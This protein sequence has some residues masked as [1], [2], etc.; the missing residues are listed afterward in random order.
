MCKFPL[1]LASFS[2]S[3][4]F[5][6]TL[7]LLL[8][9]SAEPFASSAESDDFATQGRGILYTI[10]VLDSLTEA[11]TRQSDGSYRI[12]SSLV[13][14]N[15]SRPDILQ[16]ATGLT[17]RFSKGSSLQIEGM[18]IAIGTEDAPITLTSDATGEWDGIIFNA[19]PSEQTGKHNTEQMALSTEAS[20]I[21]NARVENAH[22]GIACK[23]ASPRIESNRITHC[24][25]YAI[26]LTAA[27]P[28][29]R[30]NRISDHR[31]TMAIYVAS[32]APQI[33]DNDL[34]LTGSQTGIIVIDST[35][36]I[37]KNRFHGGSSAITC[38]GGAPRIESNEI[39]DAKTGIS[40]SNADFIVVTN[41][42][43]NT[44][45]GI[46]V[47]RGTTTIQSNR[48]READLVAISI[49]NSPKTRIEGNIINQSQIGVYSKDAH[50]TINQNVLREN[51]YA[52]YIKSG[53]AEVRD[54]SV[55]KNTKA[56][57]AFWE[58]ATGEVADNE[59]TNNRY[60]IYAQDASPTIQRNRISGGTYGIRTQSASP[61]ISDNQITDASEGG[62]GNWEGHPKLQG[63]TILQSR[64]GIYVDGASPLITGN[65]I[66]DSRDAGIS[67]WND[68]HPD[69]GEN[70]ISGGRYE[71]FEEGQE[72]KAPEQKD[73]PQPVIANPQVSPQS[74]GG[75]V[76]DAEARATLRRGQRANPPVRETQSTEKR[77]TSEAL[78]RSDE[79]TG[80]QREPTAPPGNRPRGQPSTTPPR[81]RSSATQDNPQSEPSSI[82]QASTLFDTKDKETLRQGQRTDPGS[83]ATRSAEYELVPMPPNGGQTNT[84]YGHR[85]S[86]RPAPQHREQS[87]ELTYGQSQ[88][89]MKLEEMLADDSIALNEKI[90]KQ[91]EIG[92]LHF[93][94]GNYQQALE[95]YNWIVPHFA[96]GMEK[97]S[98]ADR[99]KTN[100]ELANIH[101]HRGLSYYELK[102][103]DN[104]TDAMRICLILNP[105]PEVEH[106]VRYLLAMS[107]LENH[108]GEMAE[109]AFLEFIEKGEKW[110]KKSDPTLLAMAYF[111]TGRLATDRGA[112]LEAIQQYGN[113]LT[114][115]LGGIQRAEALSEMGYLSFQIGNHEQ[116]QHWYGKLIEDESANSNLLAVAFLA[117]G[118]IHRAAK[119]WERAASFYRFAEQHAEQI[120]FDDAVRGEIAFKLG[121]SLYS[122]NRFADA[123]VA[124]EKAVSLEQEA[125]WF[126]DAL[127]GLARSQSEMGN[128]QAALSAYQR[129]ASI[130]ADQVRT[131]TDADKFERAQ[132]RLALSKFQIA[133]ITARTASSARDYAKLIDLYREARQ[134]GAGVQDETLRT[135]LQ[136]DALIGEAKAAE[137]LGRDETVRE[138][139]D[140]LATASRNDPVGLIQAADLLFDMKKYRSAADIYTQA[141]L[142]TRGEAQL[143]D[144]LLAH[145]WMRLGFAQFQLGQ[146]ETGGDENQNVGAE[147]ERPEIR[148][149]RQSI[150]A[151][152]QAIVHLQSMINKPQSP[153]RDAQAAIGDSFNL[154]SAILKLNNARYHAAVAHKMLGESE[155]A[156]ERFEQVIQGD[157]PEPDRQS[158]GGQ[159]D[160]FHT[161]SL[162]MLAELYED[163]GRY[164]E[165]LNTYQQASL[166]LKEAEDLALTLERLGAIS[167]Q[168]GKYD[169]AIDYYQ[170]LLQYY[171]NSRYAGAAQYFIGLCHAENENRELALAAYEKTLQNY[172]DFELSIDTY[173]NV[174]TLS[175]ALGRKAEALGYVKQLINK[176]AQ[177]NDEHAQAVVYSARNLMSNLLLADPTLHPGGAPLLV[178]QL[179]AITTSPNATPQAQANAYFELGNLHANA[180]DDEA[181][182]HAYENAKRFIIVGRQAEGDNV[183]SGATHRPH[184]LSQDE[185]GVKIGYRE[186]LIYFEHGEFAKVV[187]MGTEMLERI[188]ALG[189]SDDNAINPKSDIA[190]HLQYLL[191]TSQM[192]LN[193]LD[194]AEAFFEQAIALKPDDTEIKAYSHFYL[195]QIRERRKQGTEAI[196]AYQNVLSIATEPK[197]KEIRTEA[198]RQLARIYENGQPMDESFASTSVLDANSQS[199]KLPM[200]PGV[201]LDSALL[202][203]TQVITA[204]VNTELT[205]EALYRSGAIHERRDEPGKA[206]AAF[207]KLASRFS[208]TTQPEIR[209]MVEDAILRLPNLLSRSGNTGTAIKMAQQAL[210]VAQK[211]ADALLL[212]QAQ[213][214]LATLYYQNGDDKQRKEAVKLFKGAYENGLKTPNPDTTTGELINASMFQ[215]G[216]AAY[217]NQE[218]LSA[219]KPLD[220]FI[221]RFPKDE[222]IDTAYEYL[223][224]SYFTVADKTEPRK[225][226]ATRFSKA[227]DAFDQLV[228]RNAD[229]EK[230]SEWL[231]QSA[232]ALTFAGKTPMAIVA[233]Q[234][235]VARYPNH[236]LADD[237][238]YT[239][240]GKQ[241]ES[242][243]YD[244]ALKT[245]KQLVDGYAESEWVDE[246]TYAIAT[247]YEKLGQTETALQT[248]Q[249]VIERFPDKVV[250]VN[251]Q[252]N[253]AHHHFNL[254]EYAQS[255][256]AYKKL[257]KKNF[258][259]MDSKLQ[260]N[261]YH[262]R[263]DTENIM[264][265]KPYKAAVAVL[266]KADTGAETASDE[267]KE[268]ALEA[269]QQ[270][271][272]LIKNYP[273]CA[274]VDYALAS[275]GSA[276]EIREGWDDALKTYKQL[277]SRYKK[278]P[279]PDANIQ[280]MVDYAQGRIKDIEVFLLQKQKFGK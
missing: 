165:A 22:I 109:A 7:A 246:S 280:K 122:Q 125:A 80:V 146:Q 273:Y 73:N 262:W 172:P 258:P 175:D 94:G 86:M 116:A 275:I 228:A 238:L 89:L 53:E 49:W 87:R 26:G 237:S 264:A 58:R 219:I 56:G 269:I 218:W 191:G 270:F 185:L 45:T 14:A 265:E 200:G 57:I 236:E 102:D 96:E 39:D 111:Q 177:S 182:L 126:A 222:K 79:N 135:A 179:E 25:T 42:I 6:C 271:E 145:G 85:E 78:N 203:Y 202:F 104:A 221:R 259:A 199:E 247:C 190:G 167:R 152:D 233:Y 144:K 196:A 98:V 97:Q 17:L 229:S 92:Q 121:E 15:K 127:Y 260:N 55:H 29:V 51:G 241:F 13:I 136:K 140:M 37:A 178:E 268:Y 274:Y 76:F 255:L 278:N 230:S 272:Q 90:A 130:Y 59:I 105:Q 169:A 192:H 170:E 10:E 68:S 251:A 101:Y 71:I 81:E 93:K 201:D 211:T 161:S 20:V 160:Q 30:Q 43:N 204:D 123:A 142:A 128:P 60:G 74:D 4:R 186:T 239:V 5:C 131:V 256:A 50:L 83:D 99:D 267:E 16:L 33:I 250:A 231:Y 156:I 154:Q 38:R 107:A 114:H 134:V 174:A 234:K 163:A 82:G 208:E 31:G 24:K 216:Q 143:D 110:A 212:A 226:R 155:Q 187:E 168:Q 137:K 133:E 118:D 103:Y 61:I 254:K 157:K 245:Y 69:I 108:T 189:S 197:L 209:A 32:G 2:V 12:T 47:D 141:I 65:T 19:E 240:G 46:Y 151:Y 148:R 164:D 149:L 84:R 173:W 257:T 214:Q 120:H 11:V 249:A 8:F 180:K 75:A 188:S 54:N 159:I 91:F 184:A 132:E 207:S 162:L 227:A 18:L 9:M 44:S 62:I 64:Y 183:S 242:K 21:R 171:P 88:R 48:I 276:H 139:A 112:H 70:L 253:I 28:I 232:L 63:N 213:F 263:R 35:A 223:A 210:G 193:Q 220:D 252:A 106:R 138:T 34:K 217:Q 77:E 158:S 117:L 181:A 41:Q 147:G 124:F 3:L 244:E 153:T 52:I 248:Y 1:S 266:R 198:A 166:V 277:T 129:A 195:G 100:Q 215:A 27:D 115:G 194:E 72:W 261:A 224:W 23:S 243:Q 119:E 67:V 225:D 235:L 95:A 206:S 40:G 150:K 66:T 36:H 205:A 279:P 113:A 176:Y